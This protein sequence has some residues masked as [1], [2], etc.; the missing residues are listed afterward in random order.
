MAENPDS[1]S[2]RPRFSLMLLLLLIALIA[3]LLAWWRLQWQPTQTRP[4]NAH[5]VEPG[6]TRD[7]VNERM[8]I[9]HS[10]D[11]QRWSYRTDRDNKRQLWIT[12]EVIFEDGRVKEVRDGAESYSY[13]ERFR[14]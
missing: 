7:E 10:S 2:S 4:W 3:S 1:L 11:L 5:L 14:N 6:M 8:G 13:H 12:T 9:P